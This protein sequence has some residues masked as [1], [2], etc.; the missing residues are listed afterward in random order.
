[1]TDALCLAAHHSDETRRSARGFPGS[2]GLPNRASQDGTSKA[3]PQANCAPHESGLESSCWREA[4]A[5]INT[6]LAFWPTPQGERNVDWRDPSWALTRGLPAPYSRCR[7]A[8]SEIFLNVLKLRASLPQLLSS[9]ISTL[10]SVSR[11]AGSVRTIEHDR[12]A[13]LEVDCPSLSFDL[14]CL[15]LH[16]P[17]S[18][19]LSRSKVPHLRQNSWRSRCSSLGAVAYSCRP[20]SSRAPPDGAHAGFIGV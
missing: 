12:G 2:P 19:V 6:L 3:W 4:L 18:S 20:P 9:M 8:G 11:S 5:E 15:G 17:G 14:A 7:S 1:M 13:F 16:G 10:S